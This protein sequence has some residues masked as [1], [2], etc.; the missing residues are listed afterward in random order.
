M[1]PPPKG[2]IFLVKTVHVDAIFK[3][4]FFSTVRHLGKK[5]ALTNLVYYEKGNNC[6]KNR[7]FF[8]QRV[9]GF[10]FMLML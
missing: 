4:F 2:H 9:R 1:T 10:D 6:K 5:H 3:I 8:F 7:D